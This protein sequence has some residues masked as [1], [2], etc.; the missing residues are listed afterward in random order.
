MAKTST[1]VEK[2]FID[3]LKSLTGKDLRQWLATIKNSGIAKRNDIIKWLK[4]DSGFGHMHA[5]LLAGI[6]FNNG[7]PVYGNE[8]ELIDNQFDKYP[9]MRPLFETLKNSILN[10]DNTVRF[11]AK[12]TYVSI[13]KKRE[14]A[15]V[16]IRKGMLRMGMDLG[17]L[18]FNST[19]QKSKLTG[20]MSRIS[21]MVVI[22]SEADINTAVFEL[23]AKADKRANP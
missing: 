21:H 4:S 22:S 3:G 17:D 1:E 7:K 14:F 12:K 13:A 8:T 20:P 6:Y 16:N 15:A 5:S 23:L 2:E 9:E 19:L 11:V 18:P 10:W